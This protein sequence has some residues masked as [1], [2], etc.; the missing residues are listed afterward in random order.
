MKKIY[1]ITIFDAIRGTLVY[2]D[3]SLEMINFIFSE[4]LKE[5]GNI[6]EMVI[7]EYNSYWDY[8][9]IKSFENIKWRT[10]VYEH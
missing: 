1:E 2:E 9:V 10:H 6:K 8:K 5:T 4:K 3:R 7:I